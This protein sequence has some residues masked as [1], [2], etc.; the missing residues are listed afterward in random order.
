MNLKDKFLDYLQENVYDYR[1][2]LTDNKAAQ[3][4]ADIAVREKWKVD[5]SIELL[6]EK[7]QKENEKLA[8]DMKLQEYAFDGANKVAQD[9]IIELQK[10]NIELKV[11]LKNE[12]E[13]KL[14]YFKE[15]A[16]LKKQLNISKEKIIEVLTNFASKFNKELEDRSVLMKLRFGDAEQIAKEILKGGKHG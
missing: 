10:E 14:I 15:N 8:D 5:I 1:T 9:R 4:L 13:W 11:Q 6:I 16:N 2:E 3:D 7:L 12:I